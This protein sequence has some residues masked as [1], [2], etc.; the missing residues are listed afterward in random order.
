MKVRAFLITAAMVCASPFAGGATAWRV[1]TIPELQ[2][3]SHIRAGYEDLVWVYLPGSWSGVNCGPDWAWFNAKEDPHLLAAVL[4]ARS[5]NSPLRVYVDDSLPKMGAACHV[6]T[7]Y[8]V[9]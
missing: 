2:L 9:P 4:T 5:T 7:L 3:D 1:G 8:A 6:M